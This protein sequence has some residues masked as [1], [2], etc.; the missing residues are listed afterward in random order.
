M[1]ISKKSNF[2][3]FYTLVIVTFI[4]SVIDNLFTYMGSPDLS[5]EANPLVHTLGFSWTELLVANVFLFALYVFMVYYTFIKFQPEAVVCKSK[6]EY[7]SLVL[8]NRPDKFNWTWYKLPKSKD[9]YRFMLACLC[10][11]FAFLVPITRLKASLEWSI[12]LFNRELFESYCDIIGKF[13]I[14]TAW[15]RLDVIIEVLILAIIL[16]II[17]INREYKLNQRMLSKDV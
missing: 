16:L 1:M 17:Y 7:M 6:K 12:Y 13:S 8:F 3:M 9:G 14:T 5:K 2:F 11:V 4:V 10:F 15:G